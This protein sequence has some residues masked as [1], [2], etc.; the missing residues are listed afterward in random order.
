MKIESFLQII[1][2]IFP[3]K[4][5]SGRKFIRRLQHLQSIKSFCS[6]LECTIDIKTD[7]NRTSGGT[8]KEPVLLKHA[9]NEY[10]LMIPSDG[11]LQFQ[12]GESALIACTSD[13]R[14]N[15]LTFSKT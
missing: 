7:L 1:S 6:N 4:Q 14:P 13:N 11:K 3:L 15:S 2:L 9:G 10:Q 12:R 8:A 5:A